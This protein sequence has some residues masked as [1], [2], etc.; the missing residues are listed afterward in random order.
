MKTAARIVHALAGEPPVEGAASNAFA[1]TPAV[2]AMCGEVEERTAPADKVLGANFTDRTLFTHP[3]SDR[4]CWACTAT[5]SGK[6]PKTFRMWTVVATPG[7]ALPPSQEKAASWIGQHDGL[8]LTSK[9]D[10]TPIADTLLDPPATEWVVSI[11]ESGQKHVLPY[12]QVNRGTSGIIRMETVNIAYQ[13][14][15]FT[16]VFSH[17]LALRRLGIPSDA[18]LAG[19]PRY[20]KTRD[21]LETWRTHSEALKPYE[22]SPILS[23]AL[24]TITKGIIENANYA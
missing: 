3:E 11:A 12:A 10:T 15:T 20:I 7:Q 13:R 18:V 4:V 9:A 8:C 23:L 17:A 16:H 22:K 2:C 19:I 1:D 24:W 21:Q 14:E 5:C 6:P